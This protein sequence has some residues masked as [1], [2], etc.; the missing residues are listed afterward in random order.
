[1]WRL[2]FSALWWKIVGQVENYDHI[3]VVTETN[4]TN[5]ANESS[6][7]DT[8]G[9]FDASL[10]CYPSE[11]IAFRNPETCQI[12]PLQ[13]ERDWDKSSLKVLAAKVTCE[14]FEI[15]Q[16]CNLSQGVI[17]DRGWP[18]HEDVASTFWTNGAAGWVQLSALGLITWW[19]AS[20]TPIRKHQKMPLH[21][22]LF[23]MPWALLWWCWP[24]LVGGAL[25]AVA[26]GFMGRIV[27]MERNKMQIA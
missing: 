1:M 10:V 11:D 13:A 9:N 4:D 14:N 7:N 15:S 6:G 3:F 2:C 22:V 20:G 27:H 21:K 26:V 19:L 16:G 24:I 5:A 17:F 25:L 23:A 18:V 8:D 12:G